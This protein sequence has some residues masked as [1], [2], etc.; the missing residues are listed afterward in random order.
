M[1]NIEIITGIAIGCS[2]WQFENSTYKLRVNDISKSQF[3]I[4]QYMET[5]VHVEIKSKLVWSEYSNSNRTVLWG[6]IY[7]SWKEV[8]WNI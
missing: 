3:E 8:D 7:S 1:W 2:P 4:L 6:R 5:F